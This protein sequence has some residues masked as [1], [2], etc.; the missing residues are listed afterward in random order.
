MEAVM[1]NYEEIQNALSYIDARDRDTWFEVGAALKDELGEDGY[2]LWDNWSQSAE[3]YKSQD[4]KAVWKSIKPGHIHIASMF[5]HAKAGGYKPA[6]PYV[7]PTA[8]EQA[9][10]AAEAQVRQQAEEKARVE[11]QTAVK[12]TA[13]SI[14]NR[15]KPAA[16]N[17]PYLAAKGIT[18]AGA[19]DGLRQNPYKGD[20]NLLVP[21]MYER[22]VV[23]LQSINQEGGNH[24]AVFGFG[25]IT[26]YGITAFDLA[27][28]QEAFAALLVDGL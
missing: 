10:R 19:I 3:N 11:K 7:P 2:A 1:S 22:E 21:V 28:G 16:I 27:A 26:D 4:A 12:A 6:K 24:N 18:A 14:W 15:A 9:R 20:L 8:E 23:N 5:H 25:R 13:Q 17:H